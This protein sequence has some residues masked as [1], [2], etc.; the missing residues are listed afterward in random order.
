LQTRE[1]FLQG[2]ITVE[3][4]RSVENKYI[5]DVVAKQKANGL[6]SITDGDFRRGHWFLDFMTALEGVSMHYEITAD[7]F[8]SPILEVTGY[9]PYLL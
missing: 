6:Q 1:K 9:L 3:A 4:L 5:D 8:D 7:G 2:E